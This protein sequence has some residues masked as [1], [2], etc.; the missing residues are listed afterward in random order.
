MND[1]TVSGARERPPTIEIHPAKP[2]WAGDFRALARL[3]RTLTGVLLAEPR[4]REL[5]LNPVILHPV[6]EGVVALDALILTG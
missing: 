4:L 2:G 3:I 6:G 1:A 5:D